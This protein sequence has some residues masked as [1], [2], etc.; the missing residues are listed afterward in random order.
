MDQSPPRLTTGCSARLDE[1]LRFAA[2]AHHEDVRKSTRIP[3]V[4]HPFHVALIL[5][6]HGFSEDVVIAGLLHD[7]L[8]DPN[9]GAPAVQDRLRAVVPALRPSATDGAAFGRAVE[10]YIEDAFG[11]A[12]LDLVRH[13]TEQKRD[14]SGK[15]RD[16][17]VR[18]QEQLKV[19]EGA[20]VEQSALKA[21]DALHNLISMTMDI[22]A[23]GIGIMK[24]FNAGAASTRWYYE[25]ATELIT[26]RLGESH[27][28]SRELSGALA[29]FLAALG[30]ADSAE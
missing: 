10:R 13:V 23:D 2:A 20:T 22:R 3:Y 4:M 9:Y 16:W 25:R 5:D 18:R 30:P 7:V 17:R 27:A 11:Q 26:L 15:K 6:R 19:L 21:A 8:E 14:S 28:L 1:A 24:R 12:V 29:E